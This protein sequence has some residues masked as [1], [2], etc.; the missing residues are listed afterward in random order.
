MQ[1]YRK[2]GGMAPLIIN[3]GTRRRKAHAPAALHPGKDPSTYRSEG[4]VDTRT[5]LDSMK[6]IKICFHLLLFNFG[7]TLEGRVGSWKVQLKVWKYMETYNYHVSCLSYKSLRS[8]QIGLL[9][10]L[11]KHSC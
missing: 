8:R 2:S 5:S 7:G 9:V 3:L 6:K 11:R 1:A 4:W 10:F